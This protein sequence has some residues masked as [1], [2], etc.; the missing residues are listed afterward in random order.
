VGFLVGFI[1]FFKWAFIKNS[2]FFG[3]SNYMNT[4]DNYGRL[5]E[6]NFKTVLF[7]KNRHHLTPG[8]S[9]QNRHHLTKFRNRHHLAKF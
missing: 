8:E 5:V 2:C 7:F 4:E 9:F 1:V 3:W 6:P